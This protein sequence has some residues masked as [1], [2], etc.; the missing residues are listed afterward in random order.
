[1]DKL[2]SDPLLIIPPPKRLL[3]Q[4]QSFR[5]IED[6]RYQLLTCALEDERENISTHKNLSHKTDRHIAQMFAAEEGD[7]SS[8]NHVNG[9]RVKNWC[10]Q[11]Q[12]L[13]KCVE[14]Y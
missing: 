2:F 11:N 4:L 14:D 8:E 13:L 3:S 9:G 10:Q 6:A 5:S 1:M 7:N 12:E